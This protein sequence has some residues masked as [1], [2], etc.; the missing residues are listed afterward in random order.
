MTE[1]EWSLSQGVNDIKVYF[2]TPEVDVFPSYINYERGRYVS[3]IKDPRSYALDAF[4]LNW[5]DINFNATPLFNI[6]LNM[7]QKS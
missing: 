3:F 1:T 4:N 2:G 5:R 7:N 6:I